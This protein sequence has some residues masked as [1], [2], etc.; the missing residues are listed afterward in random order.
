MRFQSVLSRF[1]L[2][3][4][5]SSNEQSSKQNMRTC[6]V[7][8]WFVCPIDRNVNQDKTFLFTKNLI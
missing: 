7:V 1:Q 6:V 8:G 3:Q 2:Q 5:E 4:V